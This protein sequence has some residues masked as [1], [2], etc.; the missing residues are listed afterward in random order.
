[1]SHY[2]RYFLRYVRNSHNQITFSVLGTKSFGCLRLLTQGPR[3]VLNTKY[4]GPYN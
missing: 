1:M 4:F 2:K 3:V